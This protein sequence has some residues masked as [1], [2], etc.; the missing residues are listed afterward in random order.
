MEQVGAAPEATVPRVLVVDDEP[1]IGRLTMRLIAADG[2]SVE[3]ESDPA[4]ALQRMSAPEADWDVVVLD[5]SMPGMT[6]LEVLQHHRALGLPSTVIM[7]TGDRTAGTAAA[8]LRAGAFNYL[9]KPIEPGELNAMVQSA[10]RHADLRRQLSRAEQAGYLDADMLVGRS[11]AMARVRAAI[12]RL[13]RSTVSVLIAGESGT[14]KELVARALHRAGARRDRPFVALYCGALPEGLIDSE[15]FGHSRGAFTGAT[16]ARPGVFVEADGGTL[17]LDEI[18][19]MPMAVQA[20]LLRALQEGEIRAVG[21]SGSRA[22]DVRV[23]AASHVDLQAAVGSGRFR[24]DLYYRLDVVTLALPPL[25]DRLDDLPSLVAH[26][27]RKHGGAAPPNLSPA[28]LETMAGYPWPGNVRE[29]EN[30]VLHAIALAR[31]GVLDV[32]ALPPR[33]REQFAPTPAGGIGSGPTVGAV[34]IEDGVT[35]TEAKRRASHDFE[36]RYLQAVLERA[37]GSVSEAARI[38]GLDR[39]NFRR[40]LQR[41]GID[42]AR[43][44]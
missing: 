25:R 2:A 41:H 37:R 27:V 7:L 38:A 24:Q 33:V 19:E 30:A 18:G 28:A 12:E 8:C 3:F 42:P 29:L 34:T 44:K 43:F 21:A 31:G 6:G 23:I 11:A 15:L 17:F 22:V 35:L 1:E 39:T 20:R 16:Q 5:V 32:D 40:L 36:R 14:G 26:F 13:S 10:A 4:R 9:T